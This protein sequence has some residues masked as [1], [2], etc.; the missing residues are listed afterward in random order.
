MNPEDLRKARRRLR[1]TRIELAAMFGVTDRTVRRWETGSLDIPDEVRALA[2]ETNNQ[3][4]PQEME[5]IE[6][7]PAARHS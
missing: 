5:L 1:L 2:E 7:R 3:P 4:E 6:S